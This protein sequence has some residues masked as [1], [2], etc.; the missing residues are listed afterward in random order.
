MYKLN[1]EK[2]FHDVAD[3]VAVVINLTTGVYFGFNAFGTAV[4]NSLLDGAG[5]EQIAA[6][7]RKFDGC[8]ENIDTLVSDFIDTLVEKEVL[9]K[10]DDSFRD[11]EIGKDAVK[12][13][14]TPEVEE[15]SEVQDLI[16][17]DPIHEV[18]E[19]QGWPVLK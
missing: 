5:A 1:E 3:D 6:A 16:L 11:A 15:F 7:A 8:P 9:I 10:A 12:E 18:D 19:Q 2:M 4:L 13:G 17:A 14:F